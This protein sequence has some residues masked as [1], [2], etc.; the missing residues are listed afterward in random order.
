MTCDGKLAALRHGFLLPPP[1]PLRLR[2]VAAAR[3]CLGH[4]GGDEAL[5]A[6][7]RAPLLANLRRSAWLPSL[8]GG[9]R[10][11]PALS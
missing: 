3:P 1:V 5:R 4:R 11:L 10:R 8:A 9:S 7:Q 2:T 6:L